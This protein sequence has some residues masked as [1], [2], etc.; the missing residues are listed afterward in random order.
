[1]LSLTVFLVAVKSEG[2]MSSNKNLRTAIRN[3]DAARLGR[4]REEAEDG[5]LSLEGES[6]SEIQSTDVDL[7]GIDLSN[8]EWENCILDRVRFGDA[9]LEGAYF[10]GTTFLACTFV[11]THLEGTGFDGCVFRNCEIVGANVTST[12]L[13]NNQFKGGR[14][15]NVQLDDVEWRSSVF[16]DCRIENIEGLSGTL[17]SVTLRNVEVENFDTGGVTV[18]HCTVTPGA[19]VPKGF[20]AREGRRTKV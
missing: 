12:E 5:P 17:S 4:L 19:Q 7:F 8:T 20:D 2:Q 14:L 3:S 18:E 10:T 1:V 11:E 15:A 16:S 9:N 13:S 6:L